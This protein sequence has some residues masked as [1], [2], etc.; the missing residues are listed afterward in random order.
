MP[1]VAAV[2]LALVGLLQ[3]GAELRVRPTPLPRG[4][5]SEN[6]DTVH[7]ELGEHVF[8]FIVGMPRSGWMQ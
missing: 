2:L 5:V 4:W 8:G 3:V 1:V 6:I 7:R